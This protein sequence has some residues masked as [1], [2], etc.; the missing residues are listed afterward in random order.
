MFDWLDKNNIKSV[1][2]QLPY[3]KIVYKDGNYDLVD[4]TE[5]KMNLLKVF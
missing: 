1:E 4:W 5:D 2:E 3:I